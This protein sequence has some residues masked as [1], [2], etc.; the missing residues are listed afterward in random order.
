M[1]IQLFLALLLSSLLIVP[2][3]AQNFACDKNIP[4]TSQFPFCN[5]SL[6][7]ENRAKDL[8][9]RLTLQEKAQQLGN[10]AAG[11]S[12]LGVPAYEWWSEALHGVASVG[13]GVHFNATVPGATSFPAVI[14]SAA[15]FNTT[16]WFKMGQVVSTEARAMYNV[17][18]AGLT[19]W[20]PT[21]NVFRDPRWG[22]GQET[23]G[24]DPLV[25]SKYAVNYVRGL[26]EVGEE[27]NSTGNRLKVSSCCKHYTAYDIDKWKGVDRFHFDAKVTKQDLED[28][29]QP[30][31]KSCVEEG[32]VSSVMCSYNRV[33]GIPTC[34]DPDLLK[35]V[36]REQWNLDGYI[37]S[38]C[39]SIEVY[40]D[41]I[42][43]AAT[44]EDAVTLALKAG[45][46]MN[47]G[48]F[49]PRYTENAVKLNKIEESI[50]DQALIYNYIVLMR[51]GFFDGDPKLHPFGNLGP[52]DV[53]TEEHQEL[54]LDAAKQGI[55]LLDNKGALPL[56][57]NA[58][59]NLAVIGPNGNATVAMISIYAGIP[60]EYTTPLQGLQKYISSVTYAAGCPFVNCT[61]ESLAGPATKAAATADVVVLVMGLDQSIEQEDLDRENLI[62]PGYQE[63]LVKDVANATNGTM[64][65]VIM[66][67]SPVD[68]SFAK[69]ESKV[70]GILWVG[71]PGQ[72]GGDAIAQVIFGDH[73]PAGRSPFTWYPKEYS[74]QVP[75]TN[76]NLRA[77]ATDNFPGRTYRFY[78]GKPLYEFGH[79]LSYSTF[80]KFV[81]SAPSTLLVPLKSSLNP[82][83]IPSVYSS[84]QDP[85]PNGQAIDVSS[86][87]CT[88]LQ[89]VLVI[90]VRNNGPM[91]GD[92]VVLI[93]WKP[94]KSAEITGPPNMQLAAFD[95]VHVKKGNTNN[96]TLA[97][98][99]CKGLSLVDSEGQRKLV[100]GQH[101]F[102]IGSSS[103]HQVRYHLIVRLAQ[104]GRMGGFTF[105]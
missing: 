86:V 59:K 10:H 50:V 20:S 21:I 93:F 38:D 46:N 29:F 60:C 94:P 104:N 80:S 55:V 8:I 52:S 14:L 71:Y 23:P 102:I 15:S 16:L 41:R 48:D 7:Y 5:T 70:G 97:V 105:M 4:E 57:K 35:G 67:A 53:C 95:R 36:I 87:N 37:V 100:T 91:N 31:F 76:M 72:A 34:A 18:L 65:L 58:T 64:I 43:Y 24:E 56:S 44:P 25:V 79:G 63:K 96:I 62:L 101:T 78:T 42:K 51:L 9:S 88:N 77:N 90:G 84:K 99:V 6:S 2:C 74:D 19:Y 85:Y 30:P 40:Y 45:L 54:A 82:S 11:I 69:N 83:G 73:N 12:R 13:Y 68:I 61:D 17:G 32:R 39:D 47:C 49:L 1:K 3:F 27:G 103:E 66:S 89:H 75:M 22:R 81:I 92:H 98:D 33:N 26:Q 28:T